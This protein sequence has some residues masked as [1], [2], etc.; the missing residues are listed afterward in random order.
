M[1]DIFIASVL[2]FT[3]GPNTINTDQLNNAWVPNSDIHW[4]PNTTASKIAFTSCQTAVFWEY[5]GGYFFSDLSLMHS[6]KISSKQPFKHSNDRIFYKESPSSNIEYKI[7]LYPRDT[8]TC[9]GTALFKLFGKSDSGVYKVIWESCIVLNLD[10][11]TLVTPTFQSIGKCTDLIET[12]LV[13]SIITTICS[14]S[15]PGDYNTLAECYVPI[16]PFSLTLQ[17]QSFTDSTTPSIK[18][19]TT[20]NIPWEY[21]YTGG[22]LIPDALEHSGNLYPQTNG[23]NFNLAS[24]ISYNNI[25]NTWVLQETCNADSTQCWNREANI[26]TPISITKTSENDIKIIPSTPSPTSPS[27]TSPSPTS[28]S[29]TSPSPTINPLKL[30][31]VEPTY[32]TTQNPSK[33]PTLSPLLSPTTSAP[34]IDISVPESNTLLESPVNSPQSSNNTEDKDNGNI[35]IILGIVLPAVVIIGGFGVYKYKY[36]T[37]KYTQ[38]AT[39]DN[40]SWMNV[41]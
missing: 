26:N 21:E 3:S 32:H 31:L 10:G 7:E 11:Q 17:T 4:A 41:F 37:K 24:T 28:P 12:N 29:P 19:S 27:P 1:S 16:S 35:A 14:D 36:K 33:T 18:I 6:I 34:T 15:N 39:A 13:D 22:K 5:W 30:P 40:A 2:I 9:S 25:D 38:L 23:S 20:T 8:L